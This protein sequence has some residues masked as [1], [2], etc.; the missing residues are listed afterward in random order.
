MVKLRLHNAFDNRLMY[1]VYD[2]LDPKHKR[3]ILNIKPE[4][5]KKVQEP[6]VMGGSI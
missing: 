2:V 4:L 6:I 3:A 5:E 1:E